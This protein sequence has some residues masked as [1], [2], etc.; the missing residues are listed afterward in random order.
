MEVE[1]AQIIKNT[2]RSSNFTNIF[3]LGLLSNDKSELSPLFTVEA[4]RM[5]E[6]SGIGSSLGLVALSAD[7]LPSSKRRCK[8]F[9]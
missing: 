6:P 3:E 9:L 1:T 2:T 8:L 4:P 7:L 5:N